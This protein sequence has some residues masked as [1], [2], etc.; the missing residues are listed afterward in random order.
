MNLSKNRDA[1]TTLKRFQEWQR[2]M[3]PGDDSHPNHHDCAILLSK[4]AAQ[5]ILEIQ[6]NFEIPLTTNDS[7]GWISASRGTS[8]VSPVRRRSLVRAIL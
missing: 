5:P 2:T 8:A 1:E 4:Y 3:N 7:P 6:S